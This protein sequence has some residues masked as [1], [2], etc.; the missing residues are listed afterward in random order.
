MFRAM[1][2]TS[3]SPCNNR[4]ST[5]KTIET[6]ILSLQGDEYNDSFVASQESATQS[7]CPQAHN[8]LTK[9]GSK[10]PHPPGNV[11][12]SWTEFFGFCRDRSDRIA[13]HPRVQTHPRPP[14]APA[15]NKATWQATVNT[16]IV[17]AQ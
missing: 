17:A 2:Q 4:R 9:T 13:A 15:Q 14:N 5:G 3:N 12:Y 1:L 7:G 6:T 8:T 16:Q 11:L 10:P